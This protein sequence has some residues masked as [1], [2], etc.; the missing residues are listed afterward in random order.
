MA[1]WNKKLFLWGVLR[2]S[3]VNC[4]SEQPVLQQAICICSRNEDQPN[5]NRHLS[6]FPFFGSQ[7]LCS[8]AHSN[9]SLSADSLSYNAH[10]R[11]KSFTLLEPLAS[12]RM[13]EIRGSKELSIE[14]R[15]VN[16]QTSL[17]IQDGRV[18][19]A[20]TEQA[21]DMLHMDSFEVIIFSMS[22]S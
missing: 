16:L 20:K 14:D 4:L 5:K 13:D 2:G 15:L 3:R 6:D 12:G 18:Y 19:S 10:Q 9:E 7:N 17:V 22:L 21:R 1:G 8:A 11:T